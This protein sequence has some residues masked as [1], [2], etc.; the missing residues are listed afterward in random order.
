LGKK[1]ILVAEDEAKQAQLLKIRLE[2]EGY[3]LDLAGNGKEAQKKIGQED[4]QLV[5][6]DLKMPGL[7]GISLLKWIKEKYES[8]PVV[9]ITAH[10]TI[11]SAVKAMKIGAYHYITKPIDLEELSVIVNKAFRLRKLQ[12]ENIYLRNEL[13]KQ[14]EGL[15]V[16][17]S[18]AIKKM[19]NLVEKVA[20]SKST[21]LIYGK[22]G[23]GKEL[24]AKSIHY[25]SPRKDSPLVIVNSATLPENLLESELFGY[26]KGAFTGAYENK[27]GK[28]EVADEGTLFLDEVGA[29]PLGLQSKLLRVIETQEFEPLGSSKTIFSDVRIIAA[30]NVDLKE[31]TQEKQFREDLYYRLNVFPIYLPSLRQ[32]KEDIPLLVEHFIKIYQKELGKKI[33]GISKQALDI[34]IKYNWPGNVRELENVIERAIVLSEDRILST[35]LFRSIEK[36]PEEDY[37][38]LDIDYLEDLGL[39]TRQIEAINYLKENR[40]ITNRVYREINDVS[41][42]T[43]YL[44]LNELVGKNILVSQGEGKGLK[45]IIN[46]KMSQE[47]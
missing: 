32:R 15:I 28:F 14:R 33:E 7:D 23:T 16:G 18:V 42:K 21:V 6:T 31:A 26:V 10:G 40:Q 5:I 30:T 37:S 46:P 38:N 17:Q 45:Y 1:K 43:A 3:S 35:E 44:E 22:T 25:S 13:S 12:E 20:P 27:K 41:N 19:L 34:L 8:L 2:S 39:N 11:D 29:I 47:R 24:V 36:P 4:Y 9:I